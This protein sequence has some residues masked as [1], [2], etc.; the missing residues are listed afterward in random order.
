LAEFLVNFS[1]KE[2]EEA[3]EVEDLVKAIGYILRHEMVSMAAF[4]TA[5][6]V[7]VSI[8]NLMEV[9]RKSMEKSLEEEKAQLE[10]WKEDLVEEDERILEEHRRLEEE[11]AALREKE[12]EVGKEARGDQ[13]G[14]VVKFL[15]DRV[16]KSLGKLNA[17][18]KALEDSRF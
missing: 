4:A 6:M 10:K 15:G 8:C 9:E 17:R 18:L 7:A 5:D 1:T 16:D 13:V 2:G 11:W 12:K 3:D 14:R